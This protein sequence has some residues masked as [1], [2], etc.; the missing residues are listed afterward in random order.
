MKHKRALNAILLLVCL[1]IQAA[2]PTAVCAA[3]DMTTG[4]AGI[5]LIKSHESFSSAMYT[6]GHYWYVGYGSQVSKNAYPDGV[7]EEEADALLR[8]HLATIE[9]SLNSFLDRN[10]LSLTQGQFDA[11]V[12]F[13]YTYNTSWLTGS[14]ALLRMVKGET[15]LS[16]RE[17]ARAFGVWSH[18]GGVVLA[19]LAQRRMEEAALY[20]D[21]DISRADEF[22][23]LGL[24]TGDGVSYST[25]FAVYERGGTYDYFP[26]MF[27]LGY[28]LTGLE[29]SNGKT[30]HLGDTVT[31][32]VMARP[33]WEQNRYVSQSYSDVRSGQWFYDY[34]MELSDNG[35]IGGRG[36]GAYAP[37][38]P[39]LTGEALKLILLA[40]GYEEQAPTGA[41]WASGYADFARA[42]ELINETLLSDLD[43]PISRLAVAQL[44]AKALRFGQSFSSTPFA[45]TKDGYVTALSEIGVLNGMT[46]HGE[47][48]FHPE[49]TLTRAEVSA[50]VWRLRNTVALHTTQTL[51]YNSRTLPIAS[52]VGFNRYH[53]DGFSGSGI[54]MTY[55]E[56]GVTVL[57]GVDVSRYQGSIDWEAAKTDGISF[58]IMR[59]GGRYQQSGDI[60]DDVRFEE[61]Y[62][63]AKA[64]GLRI[65]VYFYSQAITASEAIEEADYVLDKLRGKEIDGPVVFDWETAGV[66]VARTNALPVSVVC[67]CAVAYCERVRAAGYTPMVYMNTYDGYIKYDVSRLTDYDIWYAGQYNRQYPQFFYDFQI[68]QYTEKG[69]VA[70]F[71]NPTDMDLWFFRDGA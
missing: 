67:D 10:S 44:A 6:D 51:T 36:N 65:G 56:P 34:V 12:D 16:R 17:T 3:S 64:A 68:W 59:V 55:T 61:Y 2:F 20:L 29:T 13:T 57:R 50:I 21:G 49:R 38:E 60:Y 32:N 52:G 26:T 27:R 43:Q 66:S 15:E 48:V 62:S 5:A 58:A 45:D 7:S 40:A 18:S 69:K 4:D 25:D 39:T 54:T 46:E 70:G 1:L 63:G 41:H 37:G 53:V 71:E 11:L 23:Y 14:S 24:S 8:A 47:Q 31:G 30:L 35:V 28:M 33:V 42:N 9:S 19:G 22:C